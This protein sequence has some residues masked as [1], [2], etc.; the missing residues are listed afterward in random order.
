MASQIRQIA[1]QINRISRELA[2]LREENK[3]LKALVIKQEVTLN[4]VLSQTRR[5]AI[6][7]SPAIVNIST[8]PSQALFASVAAT[9]AT[10]HTNL[11]RLTPLGGA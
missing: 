8:T 2:A 1:E 3:E 4:Y 11:A 7:S 6:I 9:T 10:T 5:N